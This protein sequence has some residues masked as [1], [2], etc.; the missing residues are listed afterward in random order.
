VNALTVNGICL[1]SIAMLCNPAPRSGGT[2]IAAAAQISR[3]K[4]Q[5]WVDN[6]RYT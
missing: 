5:T 4:E 2:V 3:K 6:R 1:G